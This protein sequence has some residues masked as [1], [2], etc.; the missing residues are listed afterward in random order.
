MLDY[1]YI[2]TNHYYNHDCIC[3]ETSSE[4]K[5]THLHGLMNAS[6]NKCNKLNYKSGI[7]KK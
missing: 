1:D 7:T 6:M 5:H 4:R 2:Q 3:L